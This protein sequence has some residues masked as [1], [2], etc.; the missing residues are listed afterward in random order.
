MN[1]IP[2]KLNH[3]PSTKSHPC[4]I[5]FNSFSTNLKAPYSCVLCIIMNK[6]KILTSCYR[7]SSSNFPRRLQFKILY[8]FISL[9]RGRNS[10]LPFRS[11]PLFVRHKLSDSLGTYLF[12]NLVTA[13]LI[14]FKNVQF[15]LQNG[16]MSIFHTAKIR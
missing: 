15:K 4:N 6:L 13:S 14:M 11:L 3:I 12:I 5:H 8:Q 10:W 16:N 2:S 7:S 1:H 9:Q